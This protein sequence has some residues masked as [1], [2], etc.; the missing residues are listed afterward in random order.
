MALLQVPG[1]TLLQVIEDGLKTAASEE[2]QGFDYVI[3]KVDG[4]VYKITCE[5]EADV[6]VHQIACIDGVEGFGY[7]LLIDDQKD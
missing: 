2:C 7:T 5:P 4:M 1:M 6:A 3:G